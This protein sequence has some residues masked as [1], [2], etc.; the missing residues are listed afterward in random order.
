MVLEAA[1]KQIEKLSSEVATFS[2]KLTTGQLIWHPAPGSWSIIEVLDHITTSNS[3]Y[4]SQ[5]EHNISK[6]QPNQARNYSSHKPGF[7]GSLI[8]GTVNPELRLKRKSKSSGKF[9]PTVGNSP[10]VEALLAKF[11]ES[12]TKLLALMERSR[13]VNMQGVSVKSPGVFFITYH[14]ADLYKIL[15]AHEERHWLQIN[16]I[17]L[18]PSFPKK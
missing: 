8:Y 18:N 4:F 9:R 14:L 16:D 1:I 3:L 6:A 5:L 13:G 7:W 10:N 11:N 15:G 2:K 17:L 12:Q